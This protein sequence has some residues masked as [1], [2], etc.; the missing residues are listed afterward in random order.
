MQTNRDLLDYL[1]SKNSIKNI[2]NIVFA[3]DA[4][5]IR[6]LSLELLKE[7]RGKY[8]SLK[9][10]LEE[11]DPVEQIEN[12]RQNSITQPIDKSQN[13]AYNTKPAVVQ[14]PTAVPVP[15]QAPRMSVPTRTN[16][17]DMLDQWLNKE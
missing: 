10:F 3:R 6:R 13:P 12:A 1:Y 15:P 9:H 14:A 4:F 5:Q 7:S 2:D 17:E 16:T 8:E 11:V